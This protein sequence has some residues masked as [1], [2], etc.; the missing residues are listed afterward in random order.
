MV[1]NTP[2]NSIQTQ[3]RMERAAYLNMIIHEVK[4]TTAKKQTRSV[5]KRLTDIDNPDIDHVAILGYD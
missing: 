4:Q 2:S 5:V 3:Q 1:Q